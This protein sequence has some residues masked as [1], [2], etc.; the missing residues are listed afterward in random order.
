[1]RDVVD[2]RRSRESIP[3]LIDRVEQ[4]EGGRELRKEEGRTTNRRAATDRRREGIG[5]RGSHAVSAQ[6]GIGEGTTSERAN[7]V[8]D[9]D[10][11]GGAAGWRRTEE[12]E[13]VRSHDRTGRG[14]A[15]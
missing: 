7:G 4:W 11:D 1:M 8:D 6:W 9:D 10:D 13:E 5:N 3:G 2:R 12:E 14:L 15:A